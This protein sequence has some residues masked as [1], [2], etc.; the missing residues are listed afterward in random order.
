MQRPN[1]WAKEAKLMVMA[2]TFIIGIGVIILG[3]CALY[4]GVFKPP[5]W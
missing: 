5:D 2:L 1:L 4:M 3:L